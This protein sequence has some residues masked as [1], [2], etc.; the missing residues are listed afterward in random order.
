MFTH[1]TFGKRCKAVR[2][3]FYLSR[4]FQCSSSR[5]AACTFHM[6]QSDL[7]VGF[8]FSHEPRHLQRMASRNVLNYDA[9]MVARIPCLGTLEKVTG[10]CDNKTHHNAHDVHEEFV[11]SSNNN[12]NIRVHDVH[13][14]E[15]RRRSPG[16]SSFLVLRNLLVTTTTTLTTVTT[17]RM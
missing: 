10:G 8:A 4:S 11:I 1:L 3:H 12:I 6:V 14:V 15:L 7:L 9:C 2:S 5:R 13:D 17:C 16:F